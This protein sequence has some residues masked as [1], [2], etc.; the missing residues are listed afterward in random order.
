MRLNWSGKFHKAALAV[1]AIALAGCA[2]KPLPVDD[3]QWNTYQ[4]DFARTNLTIGKVLLPMAMGW[5]KD[6][7]D[8][9]IL[10]PFPKEQLSSP[11]IAKG[12]LYAGSTDARLYATDLASGKVFWKFEA[13]SPVE[14]PPTVTEDSVCFGTSGGV[15]RCLDLDGRALWQFQARSEILSSPIVKD[16]KVFFSSSDDRLHAL[17]A[18]NGE[19]LWSYSRGTYKTVTPRV[20]SAPALSDRGNLLHL[21]SDGTVVCIS[22]GTGKELWTRKAVKEFDTSNPPR[23]TPLAD[24]GAVYVID[25]N[26]AVLV[27]SEDTGDVKGVYNTIKAKDFIL[28]DSRSIVIA[29]SDEAIAIDRGTG[30]LMWKTALGHG[31]VSSVF[32]A[33]GYLF[34]LSNFKKAPFGI[35][36]FAKD[37][38]YIE[39]LNLSDGKS[40]W[41]QALDSS[42]TADASSALE[43]VA[44]ITNDGALT[45]FEPK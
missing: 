1:A 15:M 11:A 34:V 28:P 22:A 2:S 4:G 10:R 43:R 42:I 32:S 27:L 14:A 29:G 17:D 12:R 16:G 7:S 20:Y 18:A 39:A 40:V 45:V 44:F 38:G 24:S 26:E 31:P 8:F 3:G 41:G 30:A 5:G 19:R 37:M 6:V 21:F 23:R 35:D 33:G 25:G 13:G 36:Y 9:R